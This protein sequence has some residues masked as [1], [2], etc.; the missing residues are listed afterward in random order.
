MLREGSSPELTQLQKWT[1]DLHILDKSSTGS[2]TMVMLN[3]RCE[4]LNIPMGCSIAIAHFALLL[5]GLV[6]L[7]IGRIAV[8]TA[9][10]PE[11]RIEADRPG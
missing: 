10:D 11:R 3:S 9:W 8:L 4:V 7:E 2:D 1:S 6:P 5:S